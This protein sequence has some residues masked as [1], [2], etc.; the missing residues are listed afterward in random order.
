MKKLLVGLFMFGTLFTGVHQVHAS[1]LSDALLKIQNLTKEIAQLQSKL[2]ASAVEVNLPSIAV[3]TTTP[4]WNSVYINFGISSPV[5][6]SE[7]GYCYKKST[8]NFS[9]SPIR[10]LSSYSNVSAG[11]ASLSPS[12]TYTYYIYA[13]NSYGKSISSE[14][15]FTTKAEPTV[16]DVDLSA[17]PIYLAPAVAIYWD[18]AEI[19]TSSAS[20][21]SYLNSDGYPAVTASD[22]GVCFGTSPSPTNCVASSTPKTSTGDPFY[23]K[24]LNLTPNTLYYYRAYAKNSVG[25]VYSVG[26]TFKTLTGAAVSTAVDGVWSSWINSGSCV[27]GWQI[28][29]RTCTPP[30]NGG[31]ACSGDTTKQIVCTVPT[32]TTTTTTGLSNLIASKVDSASSYVL[33]STITFN[34]TITNKGTLATTGA[35]YSHFE[36]KSSLNSSTS[37]INLPSVVSSGIVSANG[38]IVKVSSG[39]NLTTI[40]NYSIRLCADQY[41][42][43]NTA[44][45][46]TESNE[47]D[48][49]GEWT[50]FVVGDTAPITSE[51]IP[52]TNSSTNTSDPIKSSE[53][54]QEVTNP[55]N[56]SNNSCN[57]LTGTVINPGLK[58][59]LVKKLQTILYNLGYMS[60]GEIDGSYGNITSSAVK[61]FQTKKNLFADGIVGPVTMKAINSVSCGMDIK[62]EI[63]VVNQTTGT[64]SN[65]NVSVPDANQTTGDRSR[66]RTYG[67]VSTSSNNGSTTDTSVS[68]GTDIGSRTLRQGMRGEDVK[69]LQQYLGIDDDGIFGRGTA[70]SVKLWQANNE[71]GADGIFGPASA[72]KAGF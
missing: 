4:G 41:S 31:A 60:Y 62:I 49:C 48:N 22:R 7:F 24:M 70:N 57:T 59:E 15:T 18:A 43:V 29:T 27:G 23:T 45:N 71:L 6:V 40:G 8:E 10:G 30:V 11:I 47:N 63:P 39:L 26:R 9:C 12:T 13:V 53:I 1:V 34:G 66:T 44:G 36:L 54:S 55:T 2:K 72:S 33:N 3:V 52:S 51:T 20:V 58:G 50:S 42:S 21:W 35:F 5:A 17:G 46:I 65:L 38:G 32:T 19:T 25:T 61:S 56:D 37:V 16:P 64:G 28:Q 68:S 14:S 67:D 69:R